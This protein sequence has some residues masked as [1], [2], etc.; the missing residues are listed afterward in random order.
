MTVSM[1]VMSAGDGY[2]YLLRS[3][4]VGDGN[5]ALSTPLTRYYAETGTPPGRWTGAGL[6]ALRAGGLTEGDR[7]TESQLALLIGQGR[8]PMTG[9]SLGR[10]Y[11]DYKSPS[12]RIGE[13]VGEL[14]PSLTPDEVDAETARIEADEASRGC[15]RAVA[16]YDY[17]FSVPKS[18]STLWGVAD[19][20]T[21]E[22]IVAAHHAAVAEMLAFMER[23][24]AATRTGVA[25]RN[26]AVAQVG[27]AGVAAAAYDHWD[28]RLGDPQ[29]HTHVVI[30]NK[31]KTLLDERWR[32]LDGRP[33]HAAVTAISAYYNAVLADRLTGTFGIGWD[34]RNRGPER[35][36]QWEITGVPDELIREF[37]SRTRA[38][39]VEKERLISEYVAT[40]GRRPSNK[41]IVELRAQATLATRPEKHVRSL[42]ALTAEWRTRAGKVL[43]ADATA[44][45]RTVTS[46][47]TPAFVGPDD[48]SEAVIDEI[49]G[50]V[51]VEV[52]QKRTTWRHWNLWAEASRQ[53]MGWRFASVEDREIVVAGIVRTAERRSVLLSPPELAPSPPEFQRDDGT[54][55]FRPRHAFVYSSAAVLDAEER[56]LA[57]A[58]DRSA[59]TIAVQDARAVTRRAQRAGKLSDEQSQ[60][61]AQIVS[62]GRRIDV[63]VGPAGAGKTTTMRALRAAWERTYGRRSV[64]GLAPSAAAAEVLANDLG[65]SCEN[66]A[67]WLH[68]HGRANPAVEL[69]PD[70]LVIIDEASMADTRTLVTITDIAVEAGAKVL[71]VGD[72]AQIDA[73]DAGGAFALLV[74]SRA[75]VATLND[76]HRFANEWER[77]ASLALRDGNPVAVSA[78]ARHDRLRA[79]T[80][81]EIATQARQA[82]QYDL[83]DGKATLLIAE[84]RQQVHAINEELRAIRL[85]TGQTLPGREAVLADEHRA[86]IGDWVITRRN[87]RTLRTLTGTW[88]RNGHRWEV[89]QVHRDG[90]MT[91]R[92]QHGH[93]ATLTLPADYVAAHV[94][95]GYA[96][97][98]HRAEGLTV[99][100]AHVLVTART[101]REHLYVAM[102]RGRDTNTAYVALDQPDETHTVPA[103][104]EVTAATVLHAVLRHAGAELSAH[105]SIRAE[106]ETWT[107]IAQLAA[108]YESLAAHAQRD[109]WSTMIRTSGLT[110]DQTDEVINSDAFGPLAAVL[111]RIEADGRDPGNVL[112]KTVG[113]RG[114]GDAEDI[115]A[116]LHH[117][118]RL[119]SSRRTSTR[120]RFVAG[121]IPAVSG[122]MPDE[123]DT[124]LSERAALIE[125]RARALAEQAVQ[126]APP[127]LQRMGTP[128]TD[129]AARDRWFHAVVTI[130]AYRDRYQIGSDVPLG[131][132]PGSVAQRADAD[133]AH[134]RDERRDRPIHDR[135]R[136]RRSVDP[137]TIR[138]PEPQHVQLSTR[139]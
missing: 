46:S 96:V 97:T 114:L 87:D 28:S 99:D 130:A 60:A 53:T 120:G 19:A 52:G 127:W 123:Y 17:T 6:A 1:R 48:V 38:I 81:D 11:P 77:A 138:R 126:T 137:G 112:K 111:R 86:S 42:A 95:L 23:E 8:D 50:R 82:W 125:S 22:L 62:S 32:S 113:R 29:L 31:V 61:V 67:K 136:E 63:L 14:D 68:E 80:T 45:S 84:T 69:K 103:D 26:G 27:V 49:G 54:S 116:V 89:T 85:R 12:E 47:G 35:N 7:V 134:H 18:V 44:W 128:P 92:R 83:R 56:L 59:R 139:A 74:S 88:V 15:H 93:R 73:V 75:D 16:G 109:R 37:S 72:P 51:L 107:S 10:A 66:T 119:A 110:P 90:S 55:V 104:D 43:G 124:A 100:T 94:D 13:R 91:V 34:L 9:E 40:H 135:R 65:I 102:T 25:A 129:P 122:P 108:E 2:R 20:N 132:R 121:L 79:G 36:P 39:E 64:V 33:M 3:V 117:R 41:I 133:R 21:Q 70:H 98:A 4:A 115:A 57:R 5:R 58:D 71:L 101:T 76:V 78:Y 24:V 106:Q 131:V 105:Q 30:S 118:L